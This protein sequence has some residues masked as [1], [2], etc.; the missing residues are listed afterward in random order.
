MESVT[1][2]LRSLYSVIRCTCI[3]NQIKSRRVFCSEGRLFGS[4][5]ENSAFDAR[6]YLSFWTDFYLT[7]KFGK[8][9]C[10]SG[11]NKR[12]LDNRKLTME[13]CKL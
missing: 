13:V 2:H 10:D 6:M 3:L 5:Q 8:F 4:A 11:T 12:W 7:Y 1:Q 9:V